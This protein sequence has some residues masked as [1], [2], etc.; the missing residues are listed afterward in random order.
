MLRTKIFDKQYL[1]LLED[2]AAFGKPIHNT[3]TNQTCRVLFGKSLEWS[4]TTAPILLSRKLKYEAIVNELKWFMSGSTNESDLAAMGTNIWKPWARETDDL[5]PIYG[6]QWSRQLPDVLRKIK[7]GVDDRRLIVNSWQID[8][9]DKAVL[10]PCHYTFQFV[11]TDK[12]N[13]LANMRSADLP[14]GVPFNI[15]SYWTLL[16]VVSKWASVKAGEVKLVMA[17]CHIYE[18]QLA[19]VE[20]L[21]E[22]SEN[23]NWFGSSP[24]VEFDVNTE[25]EP[26]ELYKNFTWTLNNYEPLP[27]IKFPV[28]V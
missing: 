12:L 15:A 4:S 1:E 17:N 25:C 11:M 14:V 21:L 8:S 26:E 28:A 22:Q 19:S 13:L 18:D 16:Q 6:Y 5:G 9:I 3:R 7:A 23:I 27:H 2:V 20:K 10:P 24:T